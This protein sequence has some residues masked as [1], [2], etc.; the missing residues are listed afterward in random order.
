MRRLTALIIV[1][2]AAMVAAPAKADLINQVLITDTATLWEA[3]MRDTVLTTVAPFEIGGASWSVKV[4]QDDLDGDALSPK[5]DISVRVRHLV[6]PHAGEDPTIVDLFAVLNDV[7]PGAAHIV[8]WEQAA[9]SFHP[10]ASSPNVQHFDFLQIRYDPTNVVGIG[11]LSIRANHGFDQIPLNGP[12]PEPGT[13]LLLGS[14][15]VGLGAWRRRKSA[16]KDD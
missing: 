15:L 9:S 8:Q 3:T 5:D 6:Q 7:V 2:G 4:G 12:L 11:K 1:A 16:R 14:G 13:L 10:P